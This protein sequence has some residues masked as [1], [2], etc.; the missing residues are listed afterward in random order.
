MFLFSLYPITHITQS[1]LSGW[2]NY[3]DDYNLIVY[4]YGHSESKMR[5]NT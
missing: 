1:G 4:R 5:E 3:F 2:E